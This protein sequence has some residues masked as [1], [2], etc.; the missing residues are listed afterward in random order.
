MGTKHPTPAGV[1][2]FTKEGKENKFL[3]KS[4][5][6]RSIAWG[7]DTK[8]MRM[9]KKKHTDERILACEEY[10]RW[11]NMIAADKPV[12][13]EIGCG[14]GDFICGTAQKFPDMNFIAVEKI[15]DVIVTAMEKAKSLDLHNLKFVRTDARELADYFASSEISGI[16]L[17]FSDPWNKRYQHNKRLTHP[18]FLEIYK[19]ILKP[20]AKIILKTDNQEFFDFSV[21]NLSASGFTVENLTYNLYES[22]FLDGNIQTEYE[23]NF[24]AQNIAICYL[25]AV[26]D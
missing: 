3:S 19:K 6:R 8:Y 7:I 15:P 10:T 9:R 25:A 24:V 21:K 22:E 16:Y 1:T 2:L 23:K 11:K 4:N 26:F 12:Y 5:S 13:L 17:N 20:G 18:S 14:K